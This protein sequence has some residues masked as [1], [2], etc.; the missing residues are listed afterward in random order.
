VLAEAEGRETRADHPPRSPDDAAEDNG[1]PT[2]GLRVTDGKDGGSSPTEEG[3]QPRSDAA[4]PFTYPELRAFEA[5]APFLRRNPRY[6][7]RLVNVYRLV[8][9]LARARAESLIL[10]NPEATIHW[11]V[12]WGQ[13]P[14]TGHVMF[15]RYEDLLTEWNG[16]VPDAVAAQ[17]PLS[18]LHA[19]AQPLLDQATAAK[20][21]DEPD[22]LRRLISLEF[23]GFGWRD[24]RVIRKYTF[25]FNP[26]VQEELRALA[27]GS[28]ANN[29]GSGNPRT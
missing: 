18:Y 28:P 22:L 6:L 13:W 5:V 9:A 7:K 14:Y 4:V 25:N 8:R 10:T 29:G 26:A 3:K 24:L 27:R 11:L 16:T 2:D 12:F 15:E 20:M 21:D 17:K 23:E 19:A 1:D